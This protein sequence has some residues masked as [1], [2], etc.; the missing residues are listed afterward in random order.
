M[1]DRRLTEYE[2]RSIYQDL[3]RN[4]E[5]NP[6]LHDFYNSFNKCLEKA[7]EATGYDMEGD[8]IFDEDVYDTLS[9]YIIESLGWLWK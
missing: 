9:G 5:L 7:Y 4:K 2:K 6:L 8:S 3:N 1:D